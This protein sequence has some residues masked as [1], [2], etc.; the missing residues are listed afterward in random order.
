[1]TAPGKSPLMCRFMNITTVKH[2]IT[3]ENIANDAP[4][5]RKLFY[6]SLSRPPLKNRYIRK[7]PIIKLVT[8]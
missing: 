3:V 5:L 8:Q 1:M 2:Y 7:I 6:Y 4:Q